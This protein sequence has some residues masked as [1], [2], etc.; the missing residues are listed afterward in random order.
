MGVQRPRVNAKSLDAR[1]RDQV[2]IQ[3]C[4]HCHTKV[5]P[6]VDGNCPACRRSVADLDDADPGVTTV[7]L[8]DV[9]PL[10]P[11]CVG[12]GQTTTRIKILRGATADRDP[13][14]AP[15]MRFWVLQVLRLAWLLETQPRKR[16]RVP[17][18]LCRECEEAGWKLELRHIDWNNH[19]I[20]ILA[21]VK[22]KQRLVEAGY[23]DRGV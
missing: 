14:N 10:P 9:R 12:C 11:F 21:S 6:G 3:E 4:P 1:T 23:Q 18:P 13:T 20:T 2:M 16:A 7:V 17:L 5:I 8:N 22:F 19:M 15:A